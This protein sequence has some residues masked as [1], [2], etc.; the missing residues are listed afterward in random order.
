MRILPVPT[1]AYGSRLAGGASPGAE[2]AAGDD[3]GPAAARKVARGLAHADHALVPRE[4]GYVEQGLLLRTVGLSALSYDHYPVIGKTDFA[5]MFR[6]FCA[7]A[8]QRHPGNHCY[9]Q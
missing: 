5:R 9:G 2:Q 4:A 1:S 3:G 7:V 8:L 6:T